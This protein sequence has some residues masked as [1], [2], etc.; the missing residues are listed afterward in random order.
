MAVCTTCLQPGITTPHDCP[1]YG[2]IQLTR[3]LGHGLIVDHAPARARIALSV[4]VDAKWGARL[5]RS[6]LV[7]IGDQVLYRV[8]GYD[9]ESAALLLDLVED[10][11]PAVKTPAAPNLSKEQH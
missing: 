11:R 2:D 7:N 10:W 3:K 8:T 1:G 4:L 6:D 9:P 5:E